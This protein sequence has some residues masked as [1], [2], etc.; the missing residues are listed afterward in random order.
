MKGGG[1]DW[2]GQMNLCNYPA[3]Y[4]VLTYCLYPLDFEYVVAIEFRFN[5]RKCV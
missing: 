5:M 2:L 3:I 4:F 1:F